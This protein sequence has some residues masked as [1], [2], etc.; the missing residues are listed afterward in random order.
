MLG[1]VRFT[2]SLA[3]HRVEKDAEGRA[4]H[5]KRYAAPIQVVE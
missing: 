3:N 1:R 5:P 4:S 2:K